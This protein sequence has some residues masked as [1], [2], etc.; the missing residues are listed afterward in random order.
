MFL[1]SIRDLYAPAD[2]CAVIVMN[3]LMLV[4]NL[5][6]LPQVAAAPVGLAA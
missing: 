1:P 4:A 2:I 5:H 3:P 6:V